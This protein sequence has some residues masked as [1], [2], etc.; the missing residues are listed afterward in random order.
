[1]KGTLKLLCLIAFLATGMLALQS[2]GTATLYYWGSEEG[3][4][5]N[6]ATPYETLTYNDYKAQTPQT[7]CA[8]LCMYQKMVTRTN[9]SRREA[10][11]LGG[12]RGVPAPGICAEYAF[13]LMQPEVASIFEQNATPAQ[14]QALGISDYATTFPVLS[15]QMFKKEV[16]LYP[17]AA[18][19]LKPYLN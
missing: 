6:G 18:T 11:A 17:E 10:K 8:L 13:L 15:R 14:K 12:S 5:Q 2:C 3:L 7:V 9:V 1:M 16:E 4:T 19:F